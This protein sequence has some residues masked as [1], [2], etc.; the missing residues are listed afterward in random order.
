MILEDGHVVAAWGDVS[1]RLVSWSIRKSLLSA[2]Y[3]IEVGRGRIDPESTLGELGIDDDTPLTPSEKKARIV[4]L[5]R[6]RSGVFLPVAF[7]TPLMRTSRPARG[8]HAPGSFFFYN[9]WDFNAL[10]TIFEEQSGTTIGVAFARD[11]AGPLGM[12]DFRASDVYWLRGPPSRHGAFHFTIST[13]DLARFGQLYLDGGC[14]DRKRIVAA[15]WVQRSTTSMAPVQFAGRDP[16]GYEYLWWVADRGVHLPGVRLDDAFSAQGA[17]GHYLLVLPRQGLVIVH[18]GTNEPAS[19]SIA[20]VSAA[21]LRPG[22]SPAQ[23]GEL[24]RLVLQAQHR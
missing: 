7:E 16:G 12:Q 15:D 13:R 19:H 4:D 10:G 11:I 22:I 6:A 5:L 1:R 24:V 20:D 9:N 23:F 18:R 17:G 14:V 8:S 21:G 3:G 2:L